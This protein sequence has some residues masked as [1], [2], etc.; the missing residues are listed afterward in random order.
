MFHL[1]LKYLLKYDEQNRKIIAVI[2]RGL[3]ASIVL[4]NT[5]ESCTVK[6]F[7][8]LSLVNLFC[9]YFFIE[10]SSALSKKADFDFLIFVIQRSEQ[11]EHCS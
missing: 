2:I 11:T 8:Q 3:L 7:V 9:S 5:K 1:P 10:T 6:F 4:N